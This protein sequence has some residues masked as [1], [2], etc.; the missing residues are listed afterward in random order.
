MAPANAALMNVRLVVLI[1]PFIVDC[2]ANDT[3]DVSAHPVVLV[4]S[5]PL[6]DLVVYRTLGQYFFRAVVIYDALVAATKGP[7]RNAGVGHGS[8]WHAD[9]IDKQRTSSPISWR[10][11]FQEAHIVGKIIAGELRVAKFNDKVRDVVAT[12]DRECGI[13]IILKKAVL[14]LAPQWNKLAGLHMPGHARGTI[15]EAHGYGVHSVQDELSF[16]E[17]HILRVLHEED[18]HVL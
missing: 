1:V 10:S 5:M 14:S 9:D 18:V 16:A 4:S 17:A 6:W 7:A 12:K 15:G 8:R 3:V 2:Q 11:A 13:R